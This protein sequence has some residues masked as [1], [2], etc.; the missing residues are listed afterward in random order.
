MNLVEKRRR[1]DAVKALIASDGWAIVKEYVEKDILLAAR[2]L[3]ADPTMPHDVVTFRRG[4]MFAADA[5]VSTPDRIFVVLDN[6]ITL[7]EAE[8]QISQPAAEDPAKAG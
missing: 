3:A 7:E 6:Q 8:A 1:R 4:S 2:Q 5:L